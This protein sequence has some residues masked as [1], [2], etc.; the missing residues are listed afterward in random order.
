MTTAFSLFTSECPY[1]LSS[2]VLNNQHP[3]TRIAFLI[4]IPHFSCLHS[5]PFSQVIITA[6][7]VSFKLG[8]VVTPTAKR[9]IHEFSLM[10]VHFME[11]NN[12]PG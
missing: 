8:S 6:F 12:W 5:I 1:F 3:S 2:R 4:P 7:P 9:I 11:I 10:T